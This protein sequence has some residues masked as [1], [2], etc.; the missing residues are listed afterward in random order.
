MRLPTVADIE[1][2]LPRPEDFPTKGTLTFPRP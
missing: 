1:K 2:H